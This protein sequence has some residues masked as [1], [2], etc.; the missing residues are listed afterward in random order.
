MSLDR[1]YL[2]FVLIAAMLLRLFTYQ[3]M[4]STEAR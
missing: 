2:W 4:D 1:K 3:L